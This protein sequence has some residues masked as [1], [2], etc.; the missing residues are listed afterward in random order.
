M[1]DEFNSVKSTTY[2]PSNRPSK[3]TAPP[4]NSNGHAAAPAAPPEVKPRKRSIVALLVDIAALGISVKYDSFAQVVS[5]TGVGAPFDGV[6]S[7]AAIGEIWRR[8]HERGIKQVP[9]EAALLALLLTE[10]HRHEFHPVRDWLDSLRWDNT[11]RI[12]QWLSTYL[13]AELSE[14]TTAVGRITLVAAVRRVRQPG[15]KFDCVLVLEGRQGAGKSS[16]VRA[17]AGRPEWFSDSF[18]PFDD[19]RKQVE[20]LLG[21]WVVEYPELAGLRRSD[22]ERVK[23]FL[24]RQSDR[25]RLAYGRLPIEIQR[26]SIFIG[27]VNPGESYLTDLTGNRRFWPVEITNIDLD[28]FQRDIPQLWA[29]AAALEAAGESIQLPEHLWAAAA[30][31]QGQRLNYP[32]YVDVFA[33]YISDREEGVISPAA[34]W[35]IL[36]VQPSDQPKYRREVGLAMQFLGFSLVQIRGRADNICGLSRGARVYAKNPTGR[37]T[38]DLPQIWL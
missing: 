13:G 20:A 30:E 29:E 32:A 9:A 26:Q 5:V 10:A 11:P 1:D 22:R 2:R 7:D 8:L 12:D 28:T 23:A 16:A 35:R 15:C 38:G 37:P 36:G 21:K 27:T 18:P 31:Q 17:L 6:L 3:P 25:A 34:L 4:T 14:Y 19:D 24:S 33:P